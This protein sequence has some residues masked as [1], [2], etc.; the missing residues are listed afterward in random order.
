MERLEQ[1]ADLPAAK[2][3]ELVFVQGPEILAIDPHAAR[4]RALDAADHREQ[5]R[6]A[7]SRGPHHTHRAAR[8]HIQVHA[9]QNLDR[10]GGARERDVYVAQLDHGGALGCGERHGETDGSIAP[11]AQ[12]CAGACDHPGRARCHG[13][14]RMP[15]RRARRFADH[16]LRPR[17]RGGVPR[18]AGAGA[19]GRGSRLR[20][21]GRRGR[22][23][24][25]GRRVSR[26][27][28]GC[29]RIGRAT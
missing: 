8:W 24:H 10:T 20:R 27:W 7:G 14:R 28:I 25:D 12:G 26:A 2:R 17:R 9:A 5:G 4:G 3:G 15:D 19:A 6:L 1:D 18:A 21:I 23:R 22:R 16:R 13:E 11:A 29:S